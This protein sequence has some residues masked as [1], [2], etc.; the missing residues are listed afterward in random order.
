MDGEALAFDDGLGGIGREGLLVIGALLALLL[1][2]PLVLVAALGS[3]AGSGHSGTAATASATALA[4]IPPEQLAVMQQVGRQTGI[5][6][7][8]FAGIARVESGFGRNMATSS[9][10]AIGY[11]QFLPATW[12]SYGNGGNPYDFHDVI[13]AMGRLLLASGAP[14]NLRNAIYAYNHSWDYVDT[15]LSY[16][17]RYAT[18]SSS[19][20]PDQPAGDAIAPSGAQARALAAARSR[21]GSPY[22]W[23]AAGPNAFDCS[24]LVQWAYR[25]AGVTAPRTAQQQFDW[26]RP[27]ALAELQPGD[28]LFYQ[29]TYPSSDRITHVSIY[30]GDGTMLLA[31]HEG[32]FVKLVPLSD[33]YWRAHF[34]SAGRVP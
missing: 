6:W 10:G 15:V 2:P 22:V 13:P 29:G 25:Q 1:L 34:V 32:D 28:L 12:A 9:A 23:G 33:P 30:A 19:G 31:T 18:A 8:V 4:E 27:V 16:A 5:P 3:L 24:G 17:A 20:G 7:Q 26:A 11:G 21:V 14:A